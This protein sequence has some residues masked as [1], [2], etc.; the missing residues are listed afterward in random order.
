MAECDPATAAVATYWEARDGLDLAR[1]E[2][3]AA[4]FDASSVQKSA[5]SE[6]FERAE[7][8]RS[9]AGKA[10][11]RALRRLDAAR[12]ELAA[13]APTTPRGAIEM[14]TAALAE[15]SEPFDNLGS[16]KVFC[17]AS[18]P[19]LLRSLRD[20]MELWEGEAPTLKAGEPE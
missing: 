11:C 20:A 4:W 17:E 8:I 12:N 3:R 13:V 18:V 2:D 14:L 6:A 19:E 5:G 10:Y 1:R 15:F 16:K 7:A 9:D